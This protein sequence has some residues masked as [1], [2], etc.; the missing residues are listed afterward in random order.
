MSYFSR[1]NSNSENDNIVVLENRG[2]EHQNSNTTF[3]TLENDDTDLEYNSV[4]ID[5]E[6]QP[7]KGSYAEY[8]ESSDIFLNS[9]KL[10]KK[11]VTEY[12][13]S[14][15]ASS[16][17]KRTSK[18]EIVTEEERDD[19]KDRTIALDSLIEEMDQQTSSISNTHNSSADEIDSLEHS[20]TTSISSLESLTK[21]VSQIAAKQQ[22]RK[23]EVV[24]YPG[25]GCGCFCGFFC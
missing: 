19:S 18:P 11:A 8:S 9:E 23:I 10:Y 22:K 15:S 1:E 16:I 25:D 13:E 17:L 6:N 14:S 12:S 21:E 4:S 20:A 7:K 3:L 2:A 5:S 24:G